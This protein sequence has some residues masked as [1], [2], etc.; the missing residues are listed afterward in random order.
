MSTEENP[1]SVKAK[2][3]NNRNPKF[4]YI[5]ADNMQWLWYPLV[6]VKGCSFIPSSVFCVAEI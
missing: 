3:M 6:K 4:L 1:A 5:K 2:G